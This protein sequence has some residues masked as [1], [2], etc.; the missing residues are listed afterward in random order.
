LY[1]SRNNPLQG[2]VSIIAE[3]AEKRRTIE[4]DLDANAPAEIDLGVD[5]PSGYWK[6]IASYTNSGGEV[7]EAS[8]FFVV[9]TSEQVRFELKNSTLT[10]I[11]TGNTRYTKTIQILIG[12]TVG[13]KLVDLDVGD[14][15][16]FR[17]IAPSGTYNIRVTDGKTTVAQSGVS[18]TGQA[19]GVLDE[20][21]LSR[22]PMT[23]EIK[24]E[25]ESP[26]GEAEGSS[27]WGS[28]GF[29]YIF[30][31][32]VFG[33]AILLVIERKSRHAALSH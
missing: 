26:Y 12:E 22:T 20:R 6:V 3:D 17:L 9:E 33:A 23:G 21:P 8:A 11:N 4:K 2:S 13:T 24:S 14:R 1:D 27:M 25:S 31:L 18:L 29:A 30:I 16:S 28:K 5:A 10:I 15:T 19:I 32:V 7:V